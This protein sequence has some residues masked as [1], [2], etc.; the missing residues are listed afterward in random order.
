M[1]Y[2]NGRR[3]TFSDVTRDL[4]IIATMNPRPTAFLEMEM[5]TPCALVERVRD[6][7]ERHLQC[8]NGGRCA[9]GVWKLWQESPIP[10]GT[11]PS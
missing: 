1:I 11:P 8:R 5:G 7:M 10:L 2:W 4:S 9:E 3:T 6:E